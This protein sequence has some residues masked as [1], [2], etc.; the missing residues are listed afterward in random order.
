MLTIAFRKVPKN[1]GEASEVRWCVWCFDHQD[2]HRFTA[3]N[4][5]AARDETICLLVVMNSG[6][7]QY[8]G[9]SWLACTATIIHAPST[10]VFCVPYRIHACLSWESGSGRASN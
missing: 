1:D 9:A 6:V 2:R 3:E 7:A 5:P 4:F 8:G 10:R